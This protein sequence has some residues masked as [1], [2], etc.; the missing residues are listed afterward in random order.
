[1]YRTYKNRFRKI[2]LTKVL[3]LTPVFMDLTD[4]KLTAYLNGGFVSENFGKFVN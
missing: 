1:M 4:S 2:W 3:R